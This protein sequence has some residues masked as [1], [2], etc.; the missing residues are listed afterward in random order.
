MSRANPLWGAPHIHGELLKLGFEIAQSTVARYMCRSRLPPSQGWHTFLSNHAEGIAAIDLFVLPTIAFRILYCLVI[1]RHGRR[2]LLSFSVTE[3][4]TAEWISRQ[5]TEAFPWDQAPRYLIRD[6]DTSY[7]PVFMQRLR[8][9]GIRD[10][11]ISFRSPWQNAYVERLICHGRFLVLL[12]ILRNLSFIARV[13]DKVQWLYAVQIAEKTALVIL[14][15]TPFCNIDCAYCYLPDR[16]NRTRMNVDKYE[17]LF[18]RLLTFPTLRDDITLVWHAGEPLVLGVDYYQDV[19]SS[20]QGVSP[21]ELLVNHA[22]QTNGTLLNDKWCELFR[23]W[24]VNVGVSIDGPRPIHDASRVTRKGTGTFDTTIAGINCL[25]ANGIPFHVITVLTP[26]SLAKPEMLFEFYKHHDIRNVAFN[27]EEKEGTNTRSTFDLNYR[28]SRVVEFF[29]KLVELIVE[30]NYPMEVREFEQALSTIRF[31]GD[32]DFINEQVLPFGIVTIDVH[33]NVYTFSPELAGMK[34]AE[35]DN[36]S[37]GNIF[38]HSFDELV[39]SLNLRRMFDQIATGTEECQRTCSYFSVCKG[40]APANKLFENGSF[41]SAE[42]IFCQLTKQRVTD[43]VLSTIE[44]KLGGTPGKSGY[45]R[46]M[47][48]IL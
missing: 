48:G 37:I 31:A 47:S 38:D 43:F 22:F 19:F 33:G 7:G 40:G 14:Q 23:E 39:A 36:F 6:R 42:T 4:P 2:I 20:L 28:Q 26:D 17:P 27:I 11:P 15:P 30:H 9:M 1:I 5:I 32:S 24:N 18:R 8:A 10:R 21:K 29:S 34:T 35:F 25:K 41:A 13:D 3:N 16:R 45:F 44:N 46:S 12:L